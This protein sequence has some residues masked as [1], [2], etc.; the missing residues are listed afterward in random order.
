MT[1][2]PYGR[3]RHYANRVLAA[4]ISSLTRYCDRLIQYARL[5]ND[6]GLLFSLVENP[7]KAVAN[8]PDAIPASVAADGD[9]TAILLNGNLNHSTDIQALLE[10]LRGSVGRGSRLIAVVYNP[11]F[12]GI[13]R[14]AARLGFR[15]ANP[16]STFVT[17]TDLDNLARL[18]GYRIVRTR[19]TIYSPLRLAGIGDVINRLLPAVPLL[20]HLNFAA[21]VMLAPTVR[22][23]GQPTISVIVPTRNE[24]GNIEAALEGLQAV[25]GALPGLE[26][27]FVEGHST[28][29]TWDEIQR[30]MPRY[31][32]SFAIAAFQ[33]T[34]K[35]KGDAVRLGFARATGDVVTILD[36]DLTVPAAALPRFYEAYRDGVG[37]FINGSRLVYATESG[38]MRPLN[39][40]GNVLFAKALSTV[41][42]ARLGDSL[43][44]TKLF[45]R[46]DSDR[47]TAWRRDFGD[48][49][50]FGDFEMLFPAAVLGLGIVD[51]PIRYLARTYGDTNIS[52]FRH[53][54]MLLK[55]TAI[56]F[57][58]VRLGAVR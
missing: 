13:Y 33:Q 19:S 4:E 37:D 1:P 16:P 22:P 18:S 50:P 49:D 55:M 30:L 51:L 42:S 26:V 14:L 25:R 31:T 41:L 9:R 44:G 47:F 48:F 28:D 32:A 54:W 2:L 12:A 38:A 53:G 35:G 27:V 6:D 46:R 58:R 57:F 39:R 15:A 24:H 34:G 10:G 17:Y 7:A 3:W 43:C 20:R 23:E 40:L 21:I 29:G 45:A 5:P 8:A 52:R 36:A 11:Y 56:G